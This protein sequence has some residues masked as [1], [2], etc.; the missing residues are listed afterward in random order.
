MGD[1][2]ELHALCARPCGGGW[3]FLADLKVMP[4]EEAKQL[5]EDDSR[6]WL[7]VDPAD[8]RALGQWQREQM[9]WNQWRWSNGE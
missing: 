4:L 7:L 2:P 3:V 1:K 6:Y 8:E 9:P 5:R